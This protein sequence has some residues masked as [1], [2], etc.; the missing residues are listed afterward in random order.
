MLNSIKK[1]LLG[2][3]KAIND[4][5]FK[6][7]SYYNDFVNDNFLLCT[8]MGRSGTHF[9][10]KLF[11]NSKNVDALHLDE[12]GNSTAD[13]FY[14][15]AKWY[16]LDV[17]TYPLLSSR[18]YLIKEAKSENKIFFE[19][20]PYLSLHI[21]DF[22]KHLN[23]KVILI[24][25]DPKKVIESHYNKGWYLDHKLAFQID[26]HRL[27]GYQYEYQSPNHFFGRFHP[28]TRRELDGWQTLTRVGKISWM[29]RQ[30]Y[31]TGLSELK[32]HPAKIYLVKL[33]DFDYSSYQNCCKFLG[34]SEIT[35]NR[36]EEIRTKKPGKGA[37]SSFPE[38]SEKEINEFLFY[39]NDILKDLNNQ[40][41]KSL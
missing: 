41:K 12:V 8:G 25:R 30:V 3:P 35:E 34:V 37:Y 22:I 10:A 20:N 28:N 32:S 2:S 7:L 16:G 14:Q 15:Y 24:Y 29:W 1:L 6:S 38:W 31:K 19:S 13:S 40:L 39:T 26:Q 11:D 9:M 33:E 17:D 4:N 21:S 27:P 36:F 18:N 23:T 5:P